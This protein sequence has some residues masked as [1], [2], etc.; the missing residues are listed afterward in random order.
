[1]QA[2]GGYVYKGRH[3]CQDGV[4]EA[5]SGG[6]RKMRRRARAA[7][8]AGDGVG[9]ARA[10]STDQRQR[11]RPYVTAGVALIGAS[12]IAV[13][14]TTLPD[15]ALARVDAATVLTASSYANIPL[16]LFNAIASIPANQVLAL[17]ELA[18]SLLFADNWYVPSAAN[19]WGIDVGDPPKIAAAI[20]V[21]APFPAFSK[22]LSDQIVGVLAAEVPP[23]PACAL[24]GCPP[25]VVGTYGP[26]ERI[27]G[28]D[29]LDRGLWTIAVLTGARPFPLFQSLFQ[30]PLTELMAGYTFDSDYVGYTNGGTGPYDPGFGFPGT[31]PGPDGTNLVPWADTTFTLDPSLPIRAFIENLMEEPTGIV[32]VTPTQVIDTFVSLFASQIVAFNVYAPGSPGCPAPCTGPLTTRSILQGISKVFPNNAYIKEWLIRDELRPPPPEP[33]RTTFALPG[34]PQQAD[35]VDT[36]QPG[37]EV[38]QEP[39]DDTKLLRATPFDLSKNV[40]PDLAPEAGDPAVTEQTGTEVAPLAAPVS[41][42]TGEPV[43]TPGEPAAVPPE[44]AAAAP[45]DAPATAPVRTGPKHAR[46]AGIDDAIKKI[47]DRVNRHIA[48]ATE[49]LKGNGAKVGDKAAPTKKPGATGDSGAADTADK[50]ADKPAEKSDGDAE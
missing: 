1:M 15:T 19:I 31:I 12:A 34:A 36:E 44:D 5:P 38:P 46:P 33:P 26:P 17:N 10:V 11:L 25:F 13:T 35:E 50:P 32:T 4:V 18:A 24:E 28:I 22:A 30:V 27:T 48:K 14:P 45:T 9:A 7:A 41:P 40:L 29:W 20:K 21:L 43:V 42:P 37:E 8:A 6:N 39:S 49:A 47:G 23:N 2:G 16:N 3:R